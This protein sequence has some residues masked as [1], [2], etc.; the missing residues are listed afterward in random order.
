MRSAYDASPTQP[1]RESVRFLYVARLQTT[2]FFPDR[3]SPAIYSRGNGQATLVHNRDWS[4]GR[5][6]N[7]AGNLLAMRIV[8]NLRR[9][10][11]SAEAIRGHYWYVNPTLR[12]DAAALDALCRA[13]ALVGARGNLTFAEARQILDHPLP[14]PPPA[15]PFRRKA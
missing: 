7:P 6:Q 4:A 5:Y 13:D 3:W 1:L 8:G 10:T 9:R 11:T 12:D 14:L 15:V 2:R